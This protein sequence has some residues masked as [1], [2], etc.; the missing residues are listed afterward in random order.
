MHKHFRTVAVTASKK[1]ASNLPA[2]DYAIIYLSFAVMDGSLLDKQGGCRC[3]KIYRFLRV[4][5]AES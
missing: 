5:R 1:S 3:T 2:F 4:W